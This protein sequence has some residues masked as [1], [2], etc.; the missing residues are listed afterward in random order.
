MGETADHLHSQE[1]PSFPSLRNFLEFISV[2][3]PNG[4]GLGASDLEWTGKGVRVCAQKSISIF[5][6]QGNLC[7]SGESLQNF[8]FS[9]YLYE[10]PGR[11]SLGTSR[12][13]EEPFQ[14][15]LLILYHSNTQ[16]LTPYFQFPLSFGKKRVRAHRTQTHTHT[17][18][19]THTRNAHQQACAPWAPRLCAP[20]ASS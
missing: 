4:P 6:I 13:L 5:Q 20:L 9:S 11:Q 8:F 1:S 17:H 15:L 14:T 18:T 12:T 19:H 2:S 3:H 7:V 10:F 16:R